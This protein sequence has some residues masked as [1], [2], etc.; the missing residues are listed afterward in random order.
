MA[1][2][3]KTI[4]RMINVFYNERNRIEDLHR[5]GRPIT[6]LTN[7]NISKVRQVIDNDP[8]STYDDIIAE[9]SLS[10]GTI[11]RIINDHLRL[12]KVTSRWVH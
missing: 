4:Y 12:K 3:L 8:W 11:N 7:E 9:I 10:H 1:P 2:S 5:I 6:D